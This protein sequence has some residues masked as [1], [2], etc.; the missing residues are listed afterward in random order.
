MLFQF[1]IRSLRKRPLLNFIKVLGLALGLCGILFIT[2]FL[3]N[4]LSFDSFHTNSQR[5]Y[6]FTT[7]HPNFLNNSHFARLYNSEIIPELTDKF[8]EIENYVRLSPMRS[9]VIQFEKNF[10]TINEAFICDSTFFDLFNAKLIIGEKKSVLNSPGAM[11]VSESFAK[12]VFGTQNPVGNTLSLPAGQFYAERTDFTI[13]GVMKDFPHN[14][15]FHPELITTPAK[16]SISNWAWTYLLLTENANTENIISEFTDFVAEKENQP[17]DQVKTKAHLQKLTDIHL[18]S[19]KLREIESNGNTTNLIVLGLAALILL[20]ISLSNYASLNLGMAGFKAKF[21]AVTRILGS[22]KQMSLLYFAIESFIIILSSVLLTIALAFP[23]NAFIRN[24]FNITLLHDNWLLVFITVIIFCTLGIFAGLLPVLKKQLEN[25]NPKT[26]RS[27]STSGK[28]EVSKGIVI[29]QYTFAIVLIVAVLI[30]SRQ[31]QY[32]LN[33]SMGAREDNIICFESVHANIQQDFEI[34]KAE[35]LKHKSIESVSAM[36]EPPGGEANDMFAFE[37]EGYQPQNDQQYDRIGVFPC[38]YSFAELFQLEFLSGQNFNKNNLDHEGSGEYLINESALPILNY[39]SAKE[40]IGKDFKLISPVP[41]IEIPSGKIIGVV[42]D[43][44]LSNIKKKVGPMVLFKRDRLWLIN[45]VIAY[46]KDMR[47][48]A[49]A[50]IQQ[51]WTE[52]FP[53][54][55]LNYDHVSSM[56]NKV[57]KTELLQS[58]MLSIFTFISLFICSMGLLGLSLLVSQQKIKEIGIRK[59]NGAKI[60][61]IMTLLNKDIIKWVAIAFVIA[62]PLAYFAMHKWLENFAYKTEL[63][64]WVFALAGVLALVIALLTVSFQSWKAATRNPVEALRYE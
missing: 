34:F 3:K 63:S 60:S 55:P 30:I 35:L 31:T 27:L 29:A 47:Q 38:D 21:I 32:A 11:V 10:Y 56:Y 48:E 25:I 54:Y 41:G 45:F 37:L 13:K 19:N 8:S 2:L 51:V 1:V 36:M 6:R 42:K 24:N 57:Y 17:V 52:M 64:W 9:G 26:S 18:H 28:I 53:A 40:I 20:L 58:K 61:E 23:I 4:E 59:V 33:Q 12:K 5:I 16:G 49:L 50:D 39:S 14:S 43:F 22:N 62:T 15:H 7:T 46:N 44:H